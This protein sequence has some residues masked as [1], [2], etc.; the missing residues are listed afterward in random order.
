ILDG[1]RAT[2]HWRS[3]AEL[4]RRHPAIDV[5]PDVLYV[6]NGNLLTSAGAAAGLDLCLHLV[7]RDLGAEVAAQVARAA[8]MPLERAGGQAQFI[9]HA[10]PQNDGT[11]IGSLLA[12]IEDNLKRDLPLAALARRASMSLRG[13]V[14]GRPARCSDLATVGVLVELGRYRMRLEADR[15]EL[16]VGRAGSAIVPRHHRPVRDVLR[17]H[18][19]MLEEHAR[20][21]VSRPRLR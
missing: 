5:D 20:G 19:L 10:A 16:L 15:R 11:S 18:E 4:A 8:V 3:A 21:D 13:L 14:V 6:D 1:R 2:T 17:V 12:W 7:R 9:T